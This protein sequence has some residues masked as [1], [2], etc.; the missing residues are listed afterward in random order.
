MTALALR[1]FAC[2]ALALLAVT[3]AR[4]ALAW[5]DRPIRMIVA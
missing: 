2:L 3:A 4:P 1:R 5:P